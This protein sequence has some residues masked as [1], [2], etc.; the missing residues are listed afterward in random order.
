MAALAA[1]VPTPNRTMRQVKEQRKDIL[2][3]T[4][5]DVKSL[6]ASQDTLRPFQDEKLEIYQQEHED[7]SIAFDEAREG[8]GVLSQL[9]DQ[10][11]KEVLD[12][13]V[14][15]RRKT[16]R[17]QKKQ[18]D[19][20]KDFCKWFEDTTKANRKSWKNKFVADKT[21]ITHR[22]DNMSDTIFALDGAIEQEHQDCVAHAAAETEPLLEALERHRNFLAEQ[23]A[24]RDLEYNRFNQQ[25]QTR[26]SALRSRCA[27]EEKARREA[28]H[29]MRE[30][31]QSSL[32]SLEARIAV[33]EP[34]IQGSLENIRGRM[35]EELQTRIEHQT[36]KV[37]EMMAF[38][39][40]FEESI[41]EA[42]KRQAAAKAHL[43]KMR[44][45]LREELV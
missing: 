22:S 10:R 31:A 19:R 6:L 37:T 14:A 15:M 43:M 7:M 18:L 9:Y 12:R 13:L 40:D 41:L 5:F 34:E 24:G 38:M 3:M 20:L 23:V 42:G 36:S 16:D 28:C 11:N 39:K 25:M 4:K 33:K 32:R 1:S 21:D 27:E 45:M 44:S 29:G 17:E 8:R 30:R 26:F 2:P 35:E